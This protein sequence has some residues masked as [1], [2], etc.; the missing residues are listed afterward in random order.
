MQDPHKRHTIKK[1]LMFV[2]VTEPLCHLDG[3][4]TFRDA[5]V[6][7]LS[8]FDSRRYFLNKDTFQLLTDM[9]ST[10]GSHGR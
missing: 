1:C 6:F 7:T 3:S 9:T 4:D 2:S 10:G 5:S 8:H